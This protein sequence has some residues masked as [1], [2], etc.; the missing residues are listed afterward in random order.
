MASICRGSDFVLFIVGFTGRVLDRLSS[1][2][3]FAT[4]EWTKTLTYDPSSKLCPALYTN[5]DI[6]KP[7]VTMFCS[8]FKF[9]SLHRLYEVAVVRHEI[10]SQAKGILNG[11]EFNLISRFQAKTAPFPSNLLCGFLLMISAKASLSN[12][13]LWFYYFNK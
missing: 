2:K 8:I 13:W 3:L 6:K 1:Q 9:F 12:N 11:R 7:L 5:W 10:K 4:K